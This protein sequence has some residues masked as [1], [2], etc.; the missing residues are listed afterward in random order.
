MLERVRSLE[1]RRLWYGQFDVTLGVTSVLPLDGL[2]R[3]RRWLDALTRFDAG[4]DYGV[5]AS[6]LSQDGV[7]KDKAKCLEEAAFLER[8]LNVRDAARKIGT[9][10]PE[11]DKPLRGASGLF[12]HRLRGHLRWAQ[13]QPLSRQQRE[14]AY[15]YLH[16][17]DFVRAAIF[18]WEACASRALE[19][20]DLSTLRGHKERKEAIDRFGKNLD[21]T[22]RSGFD[23]LRALRNALAHG[24][25]SGWE[26]IRAAQKEPDKLAS[27]LE[28]ALRDFFG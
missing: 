16:R 8:T 12:R 28:M 3:V 21:R 13:E 14:L 18:G 25:P 24:D 9:L 4:G 7:P 27:T 11:L 19:E 5:F 22:R 2:M 6:L 17:G 10:L 15:Q 23:S 1:V 26:R 20:Q